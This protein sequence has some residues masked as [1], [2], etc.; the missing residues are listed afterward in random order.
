MEEAES[1]AGTWAEELKETP[2]ARAD[3]ITPIQEDMRDLRGAKPLQPQYS[4]QHK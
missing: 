3:S 1:K 4:G 2:G